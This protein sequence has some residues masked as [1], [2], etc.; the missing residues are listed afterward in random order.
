MR[1]ALLVEYCGTNYH[2]WQ[3]QNEKLP[4]VQRDLQRALSKV[5]DSPIEVICAG[6]T[7]AGVHARAQVVHFETSVERAEYSWMLGANSYLP[8]DIS[9]KWAKR[10]SDDFHARFSAKRR[11]YRYIIYNNMSR[12]ALRYKKVTWSTWPLDEGKMFEA[13]QYL[14]GEHDFSSFRAAECQAKS[15]IRTL[16]ELG[17]TRQGDDVIIEV[18]ANAFLHHMVRN[19]VGV[20][21]AIGSGKAPVSWAEEVLAAKSRRLGGVTAPAD[22]LYLIKVDYPEVFGLREKA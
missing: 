7:D 3:F 4:T 22:G 1:I 9:V 14:L 5:A 16:C 18:E 2:G 10:V 6:R 17:V 12:P 20:L 8:N 21:M 19:I 11:R 15:P 13:G